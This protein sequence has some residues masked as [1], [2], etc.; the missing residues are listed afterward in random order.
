MH[1]INKQIINNFFS[2]VNKKID[3][4][5]DMYNNLI[6]KQFWKRFTI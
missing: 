5:D 4:D 1:K 2:V 6:V 3:F